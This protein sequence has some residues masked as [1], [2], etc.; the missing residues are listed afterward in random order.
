MGVTEHWSHC[1]TNCIRWDRAP[2]PTH[3]KRGGAIRD[4][5]GAKSDGGMQTESIT[6]TDVP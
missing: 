5:G 6:H 2:C 1:D 3:R 4:G